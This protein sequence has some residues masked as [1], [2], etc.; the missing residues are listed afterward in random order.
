[1]VDGNIRLGNNICRA[2]YRDKK[3]TG[4]Q[5][6]AKPSRIQVSAAAHSLQCSIVRQIRHPAL[7]SLSDLPDHF[8]PPALP[9]LRTIVDDSSNIFYF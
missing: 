7:E 1:V 6:G 4:K 8:L 3:Q 9:A 2:K 5:K